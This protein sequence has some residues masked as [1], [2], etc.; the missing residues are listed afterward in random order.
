MRATNGA[1]RHRMIKRIQKR[2]RGYHSGRHKMYRVMCEALRRADVQA[3]ASRKQKKRTFRSLWIKRISIAC[4]AQGI[5][6]SR[7]ISGLQKADIRLDR[8]QLSELAIHQP[9]AFNQIVTTVAAVLNTPA[10][11]VVAT[12]IKGYFEKLT[13]KDGR[14]YFNLKAG[15]HEVILTSQMQPSAAAVDLLIA[16]VQARAADASAFVT[17]TANNGEI[18][19]NLTAADGTILGHSETYPTG[20]VLQKGLESVQRNGPTTKIVVR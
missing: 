1:A 16:Q 10:P 9:E 19:F 15:N 3:F 14:H 4:R 17:A 2:A 5:T 20:A 11:V 7:L 13:A 6:Y 12:G 8:K 18:Y